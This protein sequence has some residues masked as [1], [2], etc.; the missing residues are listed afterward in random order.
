MCIFSD[1]NLP[2]FL[3]VYSVQRHRGM[4]YV[5]T[6]ILP[7][8]SSYTLRIG[9]KWSNH[10]TLRNIHAAILLRTNTRLSPLEWYLIK[11]T[12][13]FFLQQDAVL[14]V[15][16]EK[17]A[18]CAVI[19]PARNSQKLLTRE[20][21]SLEKVQTFH[22]SYCHLSCHTKSR[23]II[24]DLCCSCGSRR[25]NTDLRATKHYSEPILSQAQE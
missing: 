17:V 9:H 1:D 4:Q 18:H 13:F 25:T 3:F 21:Y 16:P 11:W 15:F 19:Q 2:I 24:W 14:S 8:S 10:N 23:Q 22:F 20:K 12:V 7:Q 5:Q 6:G